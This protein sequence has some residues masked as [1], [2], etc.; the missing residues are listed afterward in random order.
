MKKLTVTFDVSVNTDK[1]VDQLGKDLNQVMSDVIGQDLFEELAK[2]MNVEIRNVIVGANI[3]EIDEAQAKFADFMAILIQ[4]AG[5]NPDNELVK[6]LL[7][8]NMHIAKSTNETP[9][10]VHHVDNIFPFPK[11][12]TIP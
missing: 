8:E 6:Q 12:K 5:E 11:N 9:E 7:P 4:V 1:S 3:A 2:R 10:P